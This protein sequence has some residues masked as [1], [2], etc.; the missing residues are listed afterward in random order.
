MYTYVIIDDERLIRLGLV[1][2]IKEIRAEEF[3]C[4]G[5][6]ANG[7]DG[8]SVIGEKNPDIVI[9]DM[10]MAKMDGVEFLQRLS[11]S[12]PGLPVIVISG[13]KAFNY[14]S[15]AIE[16][17]VVGYVLKPFSPEELEKQLLKAVTKLE[18]QK[19]IARMKEKMTSLE[20]QT[21]GNEFLRLIV[22]PWN[23]EKEENEKFLWDRWHILISIYTNKPEAL[24]ILRECAN[25][26][27]SQIYPVC[28]ENP[29]GNGQF[30][31]LCTGDKEEIS[32][33]YEQIP[34]F[35][36]GIK[37]KTW[38]HKCFVSV[39]KVFQGLAQLNYCYQKNEKI[40]RDIFITDKFR[41]FYEEDYIHKARNIVTDNELQNI[42][43]DLKYNNKNQNSILRSF[44]QRF[45]IQR[46]TLLDIGNAC[47]KL[48]TRV[49]D[50]AV[51]NHV[52]TDDIMAVFY[53]RYRYLESLEKMEKEI[54]GYINLI[55]LSIQ[56]KSYGDDYLYEQMVKYIQENYYRK[57]TLQ[58]LASQFYV[59]AA[60]C[61]SLLK[62]RMKKGL[63]TY[64]SEIRIAKAKELLDDTTM[65]VEQISK[66]IGYPN[67]K[68]FFRMFKQ[69]TT[70][71]PIEYRNRR[72]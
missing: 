21:E 2:K 30:F 59:S 72:K 56:R 45:C 63:N 43:V 9:T 18:Q 25:R 22:K 19:N 54:S 8:L 69:M 67:P 40:L 68:Y 60:Q 55:L 37:R 16:K 10:K 13:Y 64:L 27:F 61:S 44:F 23:P 66:E 65:S 58:T 48:L 34:G 41:V 5:E 53:I 71:T 70:L 42:M 35:L 6:A 49:D 36:E 3:I 57:V 31:V 28:L 20:R 11:E 4:I 32:R 39:G 62:E 52:E 47:K 17:G 24:N 29:G 46:D 26:Y 51:Q 38:E 15:Q 12:Y 7:A 33:A 14:M 1:S 50:W